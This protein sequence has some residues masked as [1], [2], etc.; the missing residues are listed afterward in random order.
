MYLHRYIIF[1]EQG[2][3]CIK[4]LLNT[5]QINLL[6]D[7]IFD[8]SLEKILADYNDTKNPEHKDFLAKVIKWEKERKDLD[9]IDYY[10]SAE[11]CIDIWQTLQQLN[12]KYYSY[13]FALITINNVISDHSGWWYVYSNV[14]A[15]IAKLELTIHFYE[16]LKIITDNKIDFIRFLREF[17]FEKAIVECKRQLGLDILQVYFGSEMRS[18]EFDGL[19]NKNINMK[20]KRC[21]S[22]I[23]FLESYLREMPHKENEDLPF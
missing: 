6:N 15:E 10:K 1:N 22:Y 21:K 8:N 7:P 5:S 16:G 4:V 17:G 20:I 23:E 13:D 11:P 3:R 2:D 18:D 12:S 9:K 19:D 14:E